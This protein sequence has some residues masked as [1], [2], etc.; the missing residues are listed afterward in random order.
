MGSSDDESQNHH[1]A[2][3]PHHTRRPMNAFL[4]FCK[5]HRSVVR[6]R[7]PHLENRSV[8]KILGE[9]WANLEPLEKGSYTELA[10]QYKEAFLKA[11]PDFKWYKLPAPPLRTLMTRPA[12]QKVPK[13]HCQVSCGPITPGK[14][15][16]ESQLGGLSSLFAA[17]P[18]VVQSAALNSTNTSLQNS[19]LL[20]HCSP[21][22]PPKKRYL[23]ENY[24]DTGQKADC[25]SLW[26]NGE[27]SKIING[28]NNSSCNSHIINNS[29]KC[30]V[31]NNCYNVTPFSKLRTHILEEQNRNI[32]L[33]LKHNGD[34]NNSYNGNNK[35]IID[36]TEL[37]NLEEDMISSNTIKESNE[38]NHVYTDELTEEKNINIVHEK[39]GA[40]DTRMTD[41]CILNGSNVTETGNSYLGNDNKCVKVSQTEK[42]EDLSND[43]QG[44]NNNKNNNNLK[45]PFISRLISD[46]F[47]LTNTINCKDNLLINNNN[48]NNTIRN[49]M[50]EDDKEGLVENDCNNLSDQRNLI[51]KNNLLKTS[52]QQIIDCVVDRM[53]YNDSSNCNNSTLVLSSVIPDSLIT[54]HDNNGNN[55]NNNNNNNNN[56]N[57][58]SQWKTKFKNVH[59]E[60][61]NN[62]TEEESTSENNNNNNTNNE[63]TTSGSFCTN[64]KC[65]SSTDE[66]NLIKQ[67]K[68]SLNG[69][70]FIKSDLSLNNE[71]NKVINNT[72]PIDNKSSHCVVSNNHNTYSNKK[73]YKKND[74]YYILNTSSHSLSSKNLK[75][76]DD[77]D[78]KNPFLNKLI[79]NGCDN[80]NEHVLENSVFT[81]NICRNNY[82]VM[83]V[84]IKDLKHKI[85]EEDD[86][87]DCTG[88]KLIVKEEINLNNNISFNNYNSTEGIK[89]EET[90]IH[91]DICPDKQYEE[92]NNVYT[93][94][95]QSCNKNSK[96][97][98]ELIDTCN[99]VGSD[100]NLFNKS[101]EN[102]KIKDVSADLNKNLVTLSSQEEITNSNISDFKN[103][104]NSNLT[105]CIIDT[106]ADEE[107]K[108]NAVKLEQN[109]VLVN[110]SFTRH[111]DLNKSKN[112]I[113]SPSCNNNKK[114]TRACKGVRY[115]EFMST[116]QLGQRRYRQKEKSTIRSSQRN[117]NIAKQ[118]SVGTYAATSFPTSDIIKKTF[119]SEKDKNM[120]DVNSDNKT[121]M[122]TKNIELSERSFN[123][124][125]EDKT[126][127]NEIN[128]N[129]ESVPVKKRIS[130]NKRK[131][132]Y[133]SNGS[134]QTRNISG[135]TMVAD[136]H[137]NNDLSQKKRF[138]TDDF[139]LEMMIEQLPPLSLEDFQLKKRARKKRN[140]HSPITCSVQSDHEET[141]NGN[142]MTESDVRLTSS[143]SS[144]V[145][146]RKRKALKK[147]IT[148]LEPGSNKKDTSVVE[149]NLLEQ[150][151]GLAT[152]AEVAA[153]ER[154]LLQ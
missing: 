81:E 10:K 94:I 64:L 63:L 4:I 151:G 141:V 102:N 99:E 89:V 121:S 146:S 134:K 78:D 72:S 150:I 153:N 66:L 96:C 11:N 76:V 12:N 136:V 25:V 70:D 29:N 87:K 104:N 85:K 62:M 93:E 51:L 110:D 131:H 142:Q 82:N 59:L 34:E 112:D 145:G 15:A 19:S 130:L 38:I 55:S 98:N 147:N 58:F 65:S 9:W 31:E 30:I 128:S 109:I 69:N 50:Y 105:P 135:E 137:D 24:L 106:E 48:N 40:D 129:N 140:T 123:L 90:A 21:P 46:E 152:L 75:N 92:T 91:N 154:K 119:N 138:K 120:M 17:P 20:S 67:D 42:L 3:P 115:R 8:T 116:S 53:C 113:S 60:L 149:V 43:N 39:I 79:I 118:C 71:I 74:S 77:G 33:E 41:N 107:N 35:I 22:K 13:L 1:D 6:Q 7:Y 143:S 103:K 47:M 97:D 126:I 122:L 108:L 45:R 36:T 54:A 84:N 139:N 18:I 111:I 133:K 125:H 23:E 16:D 57:S 101:T 68:E 86:A 127:K 95:L 88:D 28:S 27:N 100:E 37:K 144:L 83:V 26:S 124:I 5:R 56:H 14:L 114:L 132:S 2:E 61:N 52:Q 32:Q 80:K 117:L 148:R 44:Y 73:S 49:K